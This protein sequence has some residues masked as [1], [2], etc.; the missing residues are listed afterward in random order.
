MPVN[1][2]QYRGTVGSFNNRNIAP[3][4]IYSLLTWRFFRE[5]NRNIIFLVITL[6]CSITL[7]LSLRSTPLTH[8]SP[9]LLFYAPWKY[10]KAFRFSDVFRGYGKA[11][12][13][14]NGLKLNSFHT[15]IKTIYWSALITFLILIVIMFIRFMWVHP[16]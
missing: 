3:K 2:A 6:L 10:Q 11:T 15:K 16:F 9:L 12:P 13:G 4:I 1:L 7:A 14:R 5:L 8:Y